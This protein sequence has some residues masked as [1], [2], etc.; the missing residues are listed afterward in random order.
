MK[1]KDLKNEQILGLIEL[2]LVREPMTYY[3]YTI[4]NIDIE[5]VLDDSIS[6]II[7]T[8]EFSDSRYIM[9]CAT[10]YPEEFFYLLDLGVTF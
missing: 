3:K 9:G 2:R 10:L 1:I 4:T 6:F 8:K 5:N 7:S